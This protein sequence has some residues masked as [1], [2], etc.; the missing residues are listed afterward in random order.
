MTSWT[1]PK[2]HAYRAGWEDGHRDGLDEL[3][4]EPP[5]RNYCR[6]VIVSTPRVAILGATDPRP[7]MPGPDDVYWYRVHD[8]RWPEFWL[9][10]HRGYE[11]GSYLRRQRS[12]SRTLHL[13]IPSPEDI[14]P[15]GTVHYR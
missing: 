13:R 9:G 11:A 6:D 10:W 5:T 7:G 15:D 2:N 3:R 4:V 8:D 1:S 14:E 12:A